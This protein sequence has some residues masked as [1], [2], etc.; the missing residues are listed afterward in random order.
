[1][2]E[3]VALVI[4]LAVVLA[5]VVHR[6][7]GAHDRDPQATSAGVGRQV[8][9]AVAHPA[10]AEGLADL[11]WPAP[12]EDGRSSRIMTAVS[13]SPAPLVIARLQG[14]RWQ[15]VRLCG[16]PDAD[17]DPDPG[18]GA[19]MRLAADLGA[20]IG[21]AEDV[22][23]VD[24]ASDA[25]TTPERASELRVIAV[26][27]DHDAVRRALEDAEPLGDLVLALCHGPQARDHRPLLASATRLYDPAASS[28]AH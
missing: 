22:P 8:L 16:A 7:R 15:R 2:P 5:L 21:G 6:R 18:W 14:Y 1:M 23:V 20:R 27:P 26:A 17:A 13:D 19:S 10:S 11:G 12:G 24:G 9:L 3:V 4:A 28:P 25:G